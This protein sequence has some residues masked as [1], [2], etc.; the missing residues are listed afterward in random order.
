VIQRRA[1][2]RNWQK[3]LAAAWPLL[4]CC[5]LACGAATSDGTADSSNTTSSSASNSSATSSAGGSTTTGAS[6]A[7]G[8]NSANGGMGGMG[9]QVPL[10]GF[11]DIDGSCGV[12]DDMELTGSAPSHHANS[13]DFKMMMFD[14]QQLSPGGKKVHDDGNLGG[15]SLFSEIFAF[16][17]LHRC[18][19]ATLLKTE[20]EI[21][22]Q[23]PMGKKTDMVVSIDGHTIGVSVTR[24]VGFPKDAPYPLSQAQKLLD[25]KLS[26]VSQSSANV[27]PADGW[28][29]QILMVLAYA[30]E[31][32]KALEQAFAQ[33]N[34]QTKADTLLL[35]SVTHGD[36]AF[37][38]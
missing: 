3:R 25:D 32:A 27:T 16:E 17:L 38:Y 36:D 26:D 9:A 14:Y 29:K 20:G 1:T 12:L 23:D 35:V 18:E 24:A 6:G 19:L 21:G 31:H 30:D 13:I 4:L 33:A 7:T 2:T 10:G 22:Y 8:G 34:A 5:S 11:G 28:K 15:S 37:I